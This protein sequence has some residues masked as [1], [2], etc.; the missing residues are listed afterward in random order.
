M[1]HLWHTGELQRVVHDI[2]ASLEA[3]NLRKK[4]ACKLKRTVEKQLACK[5]QEHITTHY[6]C[7]LEEWAT[8]SRS[9]IGI[10]CGL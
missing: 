6:H 1:E 8:A 4:K 10:Q 3:H 9:V 5:W 7:P 2:Q